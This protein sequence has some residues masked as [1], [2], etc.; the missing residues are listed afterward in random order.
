M[1]WAAV[2]IT[3]EKQILASRLGMTPASLSRAFRELKEL[4]VRTDGGSITLTDPE[5]LGAFCHFDATK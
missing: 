1:Q 3:I 2:R 4:G 5:A